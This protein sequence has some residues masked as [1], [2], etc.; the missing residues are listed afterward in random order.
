MGGVGGGGEKGMYSQL[1]LDPPAPFPSPMSTTPPPLHP[2]FSLLKLTPY[3]ENWSRRVKHIF[4]YGNLAPH[5]LK[6]YR[7]IN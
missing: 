7:T 5:F 1:S 3:S 2:S 6:M 4:G